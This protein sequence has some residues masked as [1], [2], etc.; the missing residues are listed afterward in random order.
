MTRTMKL[1]VAAGTAVLTLAAA[2]LVAPAL[3]AD[4]VWA[5]ASERL[6]ASTK[7]QVTAA[8]P[9]R[10]QLLPSLR[11][12][13]TD[14]QASLPSGAGARAA[15]LTADLSAG[16]LM[17]GRV[18]IERATLRQL[19][20]SGLPAHPPA[21]V[22]LVM[23]GSSTTATATFDGGQL[24]L[25]GRAAAEQFAV[26]SFDLRV[27][28][29]EAGGSAAL[30]SD[31]GAR[32]VLVAKRI[33]YGGTDIGRGALAI[34]FAADGALIERAAL[35]T[36]AGIEAAVFGL[37]SV[38]AGGLRFD[39]GLEALA[40]GP[41]PVEASARLS[42][43]FDARQRQVEVTDI[44]L[45]SAGSELTGRVL[46]QQG[47]RLK[48][49]AD[50]RLDTVEA[51]AV[52]QAAF[53]L[54]PLLAVPDLELRLRIGRVSW[55]G[56]AAEGIVL[57]LTRTGSTAELKELAVRSLAGAPARAAGRLDIS[58][59]PRLA[60]NTLSLKLGAAELSGTLS[61]DFAGAVPRIA[62]DLASLAPLGYD[63]FFP[64]LPPLPPEPMTRRAAA[65]QAAA[66]RPPPRR[67]T[68]DST[69]L[70]LPPL[71]PAEISLRLAA[72][73]LL[74]RA[75]RL[76]DARL[77]LQATAQELTVD[78][79][80]GTIHGGRLEARGRAAAPDGMPR[81]AAEAT[82]AGADLR[83]LLAEQA[84]INEIAGRV[85]ASL[86]GTAA[87]RSLAELVG[88][89]SGRIELKGRDGHVTGFDLPAMSAGL[90]RLNRPT[91]LFEVVR[92]GLG[93][94]RT[95]F[96]RLDGTFRVERGIART[97]DLRLVAAAGQ[98]RTIGTI[99]LPAWTLDLTNELRL[100]EH[101]DLPPLV[102]KLNGSIDAPRRV[103]D[104][105]AL[106]AQLVRRGRTPA[107]R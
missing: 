40:S 65:A 77:A 22:V 54:A 102:F 29:L 81:F 70:S 53:V 43:S 47:Q 32:L 79:L 14:V 35:Q 101:A 92:L 94:G 58:P 19:R 48:A 96:S 24:R 10:L 95:P 97:E 68:W 3:L 88:G 59:G 67:E 71:P 39:G 105:A 33:A 46:L 30:T 61:A 87:G 4:R 93:A 69:P 103:F 13:A 49:T 107:G 18:E 51:A 26:D 72:P 104:I 84:G 85:D 20:L 52:P 2:V 42:G 90:R 37:A 98:A 17:A 99:N 21:D 75:H 82:I 44:A 27:A 66:P 28:G 64:P 7:I 5:L 63:A 55:T 31:Q 15:A 73:A 23:D 80:S 56:N 8:G 78:S 76:V 100:S 1:A 9:I 86:Q 91:D 38:E 41:A 11:L 34:T 50:L 45:R 16:G 57:D 106:Q 36:P 89:L 6:A 25:T 62:A 12:L 60:F 83:A 74:W